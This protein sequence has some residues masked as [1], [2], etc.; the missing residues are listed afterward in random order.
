M[1]EFIL[2]LS[3]EDIGNL[4]LGGE[5]HARYGLTNVTVKLDEC[6]YHAELEVSEDD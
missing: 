4:L 5:I 6:I 2:K 1:S 3:K